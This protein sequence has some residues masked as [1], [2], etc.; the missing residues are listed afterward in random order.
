ME[1]ES[2]RIGK[3]VQSEELMTKKMQGLNIHLHIPIEQ[4]IKHLVSEYVLPYEN[5][6]WY[7][8]KISDGLDKVLRWVKSEEIKKMLVETLVNRNYQ[9]MIRIL[10]EHYYDPR[11][12]HARKEY[13]GEFIDIFAE[14]PNEAAEKI[15]IE[16]KNTLFKR[17][18]TLE[19]QF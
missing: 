16:L 4:R 10:L 14:E 6:P 18:K 5:E 7:Y 19:N 13:E 12:N 1:A 3:A 9:E 11:Y 17:D 2:K 15:A 8:D